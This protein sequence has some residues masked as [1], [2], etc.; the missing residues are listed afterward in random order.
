MMRFISRKC[1][2]SFLTVLLV[3]LLLINCNEDNVMPTEN[4]TIIHGPNKPPE[5]WLSVSA[6]DIAE[7]DI[8]I[9]FYW[10][11]S[12]ID[13]EVIYYQWTRSVFDTI[14]DWYNIHSTDSIFVFINY[15]DPHNMPP[16]DCIFYIRA[17]DDDLRMDDT[18][19]SCTLNY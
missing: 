16:V 19:A 17:I 7:A 2:I 14:Y 15:Y 18:S 6:I 13:G 12:D 5:T 1:N 8:R 11:G 3:L 9:H 4:G 10:G